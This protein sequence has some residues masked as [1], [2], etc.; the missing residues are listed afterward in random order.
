MMQNVLESNASSA[1]PPLPIQ[2]F[3]DKGRIRQRMETK[4]DSL[5]LSYAMP[6]YG[7]QCPLCYKNV[8]LF[9]AVASLSLS[10]ISFVYIYI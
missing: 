7:I 5:R 3:F 9:K 10:L 4:T 1:S 2:Q 8:L 6:R